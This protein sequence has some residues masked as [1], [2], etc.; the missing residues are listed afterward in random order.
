MSVDR[1]NVAFGNFGRSVMFLIKRDGLF[2]FTHMRHEH[3][4]FEFLIENSTWPH[5][6][7]TMI[8]RGLLLAA[9]A[10][11]SDAAVGQ[12]K[13]ATAS[14]VFQTMLTATDR[15]WLSANGCSQLPPT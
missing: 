9:G 7:M 3:R 10:N 11:I 2:D 12:A 13:L 5:D 1:K 6:E 15:E 14:H 4:L 8:L